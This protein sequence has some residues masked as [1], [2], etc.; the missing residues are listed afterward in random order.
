MSESPSSQPHE[1]T[2]ASMEGK[3]PTPEFEE[4]DLS[5]Q[6]LFEF[7]FV[8]VLVVPRLRRGALSCS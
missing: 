2:M 5:A 7:S 8:E 1:R 4:V 3:T 6:D